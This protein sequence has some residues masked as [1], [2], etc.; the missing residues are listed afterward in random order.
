MLIQLPGS[1]KDHY[2]NRLYHEFTCAYQFIICVF[3]TF[4]CTTND[5]KKY[6]SWGV[7]GGNKEN[8]HYSSLK[9]VD[10][11]NVAQLQVAW[12]YHSNDS[13][14]M[15]QIQVNPVV[16]NNVLYGV[17]A[18]LKLFALDAANGKELWV[19]DPVAEAMTSG[20]SSAYFSLTPVAVL[21]I[22][23]MAKM[24]SVYSILRGQNF[25]V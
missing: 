18:K 11:A 24:I 1:K 23:Q 10:T 14:A 25:S 5:E 21:H 7:Y 4:S 22:I 19:F 2:K 15:T 16:I 20:D 3:V 9:Q 17:S 8:N 6:E 12:E 13:E